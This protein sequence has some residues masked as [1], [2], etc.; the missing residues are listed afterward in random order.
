MVHKSFNTVLEAW[1][2]SFG[3]T[4]RLSTPPSIF[5]YKPCDKSDTFF[6]KEP[7]CNISLLNSKVLASLVNLKIRAMLLSR[8]I[9]Q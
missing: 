5:D 4:D 7:Y 2:I 3:I 1:S 6:L 9:Y 8:A